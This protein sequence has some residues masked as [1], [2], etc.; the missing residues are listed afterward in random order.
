M[1]NVVILGSTGSIGR[2]ALD[3]ISRLNAKQQK[4]RILGLAAGRN[5][6]LLEKQ[7]LQFRPKYVS[8]S[9]E[10]LG[11]MLKNRLKPYI[12]KTKFFIG[13]DALV[14]IASLPKIDIII[15]GITG[16]IG[17]LPLLASIEKNNAKY[18]ALANKEPI[19][20]AGD[21]IISKLKNTKMS[22]LPVDSEHSAIFQC[23]QKVQK[24]QIK[25]IILTGSGGP[26]YNYTE[27]RM[28]SVTVR[29]ALR[30][31]SW[32]MG[33]KITID[34]ATLMNKGFEVIEAH[35][36]FDVDYEKIKVLIHPETIVHS[37]VKLIDG[38]VLAQLAIPDMRI[39]IQY[40]LTYPERVNTSL[41]ELK[42]E[43][44]RR[45]TFHKIDTDKFKCF[46][47]AQE[48]AKIGGSALAV[49]NASDEVAVNA[50]LTK[51][52]KFTDIPKIIEK[53]VSKHIGENF[54]RK[55]TLEEILEVDKWARKFA[56]SII[57]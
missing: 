48:V 53:A 13:K 41:P 22:I 4:Y 55:P 5:I 37:L 54:I 38:S 45:L 52:I 40:A 27:K 9:D 11:C 33:K 56:E 36:L 17:L 1:K 46:K 7:I 20:V 19:V 24:E 32:R 30:H 6:S 3:V 43:D 28:S 49:L 35:Y 8:V 23:L 21:L 10:K 47:I 31:P 44:I 42:L 57:V 14:K 25:E 50:F 2:N 51:K 15:F 16:I 18:I 39:P 26:F 29:E 34:S 12:R